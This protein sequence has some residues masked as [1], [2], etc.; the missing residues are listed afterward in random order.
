[1]EGSMSAV[2]TATR[3]KLTVAAYHDLGATGHLT[4]DDRVE[5]IEGE[6]IDMAPIGGPHLT[7]VNRLN[8]FFARS[9]GDRGIVSVQNPV[10][11]GRHSEPQPDLVILAPHMNARDAGVSIPKDVLLLIEV[12]D[13]TV[14]YDRG[15]KL[16]LYVRHG[17][18]DV[19]LFNLR[20]DRIEVYRAPT[21]AGYA[22]MREIGPGESIAML[23]LPDV[24]LAWETVFA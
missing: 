14:A 4:E 17:L 9:I 7:S 1:M 19:W 3:H 12:S 13:T 24:R 16:P 2:F 15:T 5:L 8:M 6:L 23:A 20:S 21:A 18:E 11:L 10:I 22:P